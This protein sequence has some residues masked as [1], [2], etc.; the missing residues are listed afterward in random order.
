MT[1]AS[2]T[3]ASKDALANL[4]AV[5]HICQ[6]LIVKQ[7]FEKNLPG[8]KRP[9]REPNRKMER[10]SFSRSVRVP[11]AAVVLC[12]VAVALGDARTLSEHY[13]PDSP[14]SARSASPR[15]QVLEAAAFKHFVDG[16][17]RNDNELY[18][19]FVPNAMAWGFLKENVP[20]FDS[21]DKE[22]NEIY[23][24][25][26]WTYRKH[27]KATPSG[28]IITEFLPAVRWAGKYNSIDCAA[29]H[30]LHEGRWLADPQ[31]LDDYSL[32]WFRKGGDPRRY[33]FWAADSLWA[34]YLVTGD[35]RLIRELLP[36]LIANYEG[37]EREHRDPNGLFWQE[38]DRDGM[39]VSIGGSGY[40]ATINSYMYG[41]AVAIA[42]IAKLAGKQDI[43]EQY[44]S[45]AAEI[46]KLVEEKLWD[47]RAQ[48]FK[49]LP[50]G[51]NAV[52][53]EVREEHG[54][55]PWYFNL[56]DADKAV[57]WDQLM[58]TNGFYAPFGPTTAERRQSKFKISYQGHEC[59]WNGPS[60]PFATS[61]TLTGLANLL[62]S[63]TPCEITRAD[64]FNLLKVYT[65]SQHRKLDDARLAPWIDENLNPITGDWIARTLLKER[66]AAIPERGKDYN[67]STY[68]DLVIS[69]LVGLR[70]RADDIVEVNPLAPVT[71]DY[72]CLDQVRYHKHWLT[73]LWDKTGA[74]YHKGQGLRVLADGGEIAASDGLTH[75]MG[76]LP[77]RQTEASAAAPSAPVAGWEKYSG[78]PIMGGK[79]GTC[80][81]VSVLKD[82]EGYRM[83]VSWR[84][85]QSIALVESKDGLRW[86]QP[87]RI[88]LGP[89]KERGWED[90]INRPVIIK[91]GDVYHLW[92]TGQAHGHSWIGYATSLDGV[93]WKRMSQKP[94]LSADKPWE[95][96]A[97]MCPDVIWDE[98]AKVYRMWYSGGQQYE[99]DAIGYATSSDGIN[100]TKN[101]DNPIF[102][103]DPS[104][105]WEKAKVT[106]CQVVQQG[107]WHIMFYIGFRDVDHAQIGVAR[108]KD[109]VT[110]WQRHPANP[111][112]R[113]DPGQWDHDA[114]YKPYAIFDG[115]K[116]LLWYNGRKGGLEQI[117]VAF[118]E[119]R[120]LDFP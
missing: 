9:R 84:P 52:L 72:F 56:P 13:I 59:Q 88:V 60:W 11:G 99:P 22:I 92:Y 21:P 110:H 119:G 43:A 107:G 19:Q 71:W 93:S 120:D 102:K 33:S 20:L 70:P 108:S 90:D 95:K 37:W 98:T 5:I 25:R 48:F 49:V 116:W 105:D 23:Y 62:D 34:R 74:R 39:E 31:Y 41:D 15:P 57:A 35:A 27:V 76:R 89:R 104:S 26:W 100:W 2:A 36:D 47:S 85:K 81:D 42:N 3:T 86:S 29:G 46:K 44:L 83:W 55:T 65:K 106:A 69:G 51:E 4:F 117:G 12:L 91:R 66:G 1:Y 97:V 58:D 28:F 118:H 8:I 32:F 79:Y 94:V 40:R 53:A 111:I 77:P 112:I 54:Y 7:R 103:S 68:C 101:K 45:K 18:T 87:P 24:F 10:K 6:T 80:F 96:E 78:N 115:Q 38:D 114:C 50:R 109:G 61:V 73:I 17:N 82:G 113:P 16:F 64:Y 63:G 75:V 14:A 30:H 67:H